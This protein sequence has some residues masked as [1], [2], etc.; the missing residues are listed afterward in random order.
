MAVFPVTEGGNLT[1]LIAKERIVA[2]GISDTKL[3]SCVLV[4]NGVS[5]PKP[6][7]PCFA[8]LFANDFFDRLPTTKRRSLSWF[9]FHASGGQVNVLCPYIRSAEQLV[10]FVRS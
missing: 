6:M 7:Q 4:C 3:L 5:F 10:K 2:G 1:R 9:G 8:M